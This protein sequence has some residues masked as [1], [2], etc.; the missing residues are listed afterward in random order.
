VPPAKFSIRRRNVW[1]DVKAAYDHFA[2]K[3]LFAAWA[4][5][6]LGDYM[7]SGLKPHPDGVS[8]GLRVKTKPPSMR[9]CRITCRS[10]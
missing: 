3:D 10:C 4:P 5:G 7:D 8:C 1:P 9:R 2:A 6:V